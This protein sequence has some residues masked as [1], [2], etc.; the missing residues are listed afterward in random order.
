MSLG[1]NFYTTSISHILLYEK[2]DV[3]SIY[4]VIDVYAYCSQRK[5]EVQSQYNGN[6]HTK[7][8][9]KISIHIY[10]YREY[11]TKL[12]FLHQC[13]S[14]NFRWRFHVRNLKEE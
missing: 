12:I 8:V 3:N 13:R 2:I 4:K 10:L 6:V 14:K 7:L 9:F 5:V 1:L 11:L